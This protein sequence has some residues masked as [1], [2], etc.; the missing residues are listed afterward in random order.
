[1][2]NSTFNGQL[3][4]EAY[5]SG[6]LE[7]LSLLECIDAYSITF[8]S[9]RGNVFLVVG[10]G[11][12]NTTDAYGIFPSIIRSGQCAAETGTRWVYEQYRAESG[13][14]FAQE[15][16]RFL[17]ELRADPDSWSPLL[18]LRVNKCFSERTGQNCKLNFSVPLVVVVIVFNAIK[19]LALLVGISQLRNDPMLT[20]GDAVASFLQRPDPSS[21]NMC[22]ISQGDIHRS[23]LGWQELQQPR[24][25]TNNLPSWSSSVKK[26]KRRMVWVA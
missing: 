26:G 14:C 9:T 19:A 25:Y 13:G 23:T 4:S 10:E 20:V 15:G 17:P 2:Y 16:Y 8:Q 3:Y 18:G 21:L 12:M 22:L 1:M 7:E 6:R 5:E 11:V 24:A